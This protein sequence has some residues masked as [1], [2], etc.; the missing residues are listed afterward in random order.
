MTRFQ[1]RLILPP[2]SL[3]HNAQIE[4]DEE[5][6]GDDQIDVPVDRRR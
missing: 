5:D 1:P 2:I 3:A 4:D 6:E